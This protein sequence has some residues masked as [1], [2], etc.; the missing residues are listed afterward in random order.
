MLDWKVLCKL[1]LS[2]SHHCQIGK[3]PPCAISRKVTHWF[4]TC[5]QSE[6]HPGTAQILRAKLLPDFTLSFYGVSLSESLWSI[7]PLQLLLVPGH[8]V[9]KRYEIF[10]LRVTRNDVGKTEKD[11]EWRQRRVRDKM[12]SCKCHVQTQTHQ[13]HSVIFIPP[14]QKSKQYVLCPLLFSVTCCTK[15]HS[16]E[17]EKPPRND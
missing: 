13:S 12:Q 16:E 7:L 8:L 9:C 15:I 17:E 1:E 6:L 10:S 11:T 2:F 5:K 14:L 3:P 4:V